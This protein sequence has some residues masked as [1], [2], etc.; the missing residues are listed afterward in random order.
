MTLSLRCKQPLSHPRAAS[1]ASERKDCNSS[2]PPHIV[3]PLARMIALKKT[4]CYVALRG[5]SYSHTTPACP[6]RRVSTF[7]HWHTAAAQSRDECSFDIRVLALVNHCAAAFPL[8]RSPALFASLASLLSDPRRCN[9]RF[10]SPSAYESIPDDFSSLQNRSTL[11][12]S[13]LTVT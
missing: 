9:R 11:Y 1:S 4:Y 2:S 10:I 5:R 7:A 8:S 3:A 6:K 13:S 12:F